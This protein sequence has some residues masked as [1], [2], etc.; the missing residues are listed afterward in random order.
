MPIAGSRAQKQ[1]GEQQPNFFHGEQKCAAKVANNQPSGVATF[2]A[3]LHGM[4]PFFQK[5]LVTIRRLRYPGSLRYW[6]R[7]YARG[8]HSGAGSSG[9]LAAYK[10]E[11]VNRFVAENG[12]MSVVELG[13]GDGQ[14][15]RLAD[16][17]AYIGLD[18]SA[19]AIARCRKIFAGDPT[20]TFAI[21]GPKN[22]QVA[23]YQSDMALSMEVIFHLTEENV[24]QKYLHDLFASA[25]KW[26]VV[27]SSDETDST[28]GI[29]PHFRPRRFTSDVPPDW[30]LRRQL[31]TPHR[32]I[33]QSDFFFF[34]KTGSSKS[35]NFAT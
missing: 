12:I 32:D 34:E 18:I 22:F 21:C 29:F 7:R 11:V 35:Y 25:R 15:L 24:Y 13:C 2:A 5:I 14:Q 9:I 4:K 27:F 1:R 6:E 30:V 31:T 28:G 8:G 33:S 17:P 16:Y 10:A 20:K 23:D 3:C 19:S 26:V